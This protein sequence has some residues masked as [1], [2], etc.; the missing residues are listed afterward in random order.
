MLKIGLYCDNPIDNIKIRELIRDCSF[1]QHHLLKVI[2]V[3]EADDVL[4]NQISIRFI[5]FEN[6]SKYKQRMLNNN[7][8][9]FIIL[10]KEENKTW[11]YHPKFHYLQ[12]PFE[13]QQ[14]DLILEDIFKTRKQST[15]VATLPHKGDK[16]FYIKDLNYIDIYHRSLYF[17]ENDKNTI[18]SII[19]KSFEKEVK[20]FLCHEELYLLKPS[21]LINVS[22][23]DQLTND[24]IV[25][26]NG[27]I[28]YYP[29]N[30]YQQLK[31]YWDKFY[32]IE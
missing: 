13:K 4:K 26:R 32:S 14:L 16:R 5:D 29:K 7:D 3:N 1:L 15:I 27:A 17:H 20:S 30:G 28:L 11:H 2:G 10:I 24:H 9:S 18:G 12:A 6:S 8:I 22:N 21:L 31:N 19:R 23:I 25:F